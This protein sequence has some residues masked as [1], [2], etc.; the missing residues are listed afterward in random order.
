MDSDR[1]GSDHPFIP[2]YVNGFK[3]PTYVTYLCVE[4]C[5]GC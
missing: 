5:T 3:Y 1:V 4:W 2:T